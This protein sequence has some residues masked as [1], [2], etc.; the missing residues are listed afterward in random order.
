MGKELR[1][2]Q[3]NW[4]LAYA[5]EIIQ[6]IF[7]T[8]VKSLYFSELQISLYQITLKYLC[9]SVMEI[10]ELLQEEIISQ[11][12]DQSCSHTRDQ[13]GQV[14]GFSAKR[15]GLGA[16]KPP[17]GFTVPLCVSLT[18]PQGLTSALQA[19][20]RGGCGCCCC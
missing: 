2:D 13:V 8:W 20:Q 19:Q 11:S 18:V 1:Q 14:I 15:V 17:Y 4:V 16:R 12:A 9:D 10:S 6:I 5:Y 7:M 3:K